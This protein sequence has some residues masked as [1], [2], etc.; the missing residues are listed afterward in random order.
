MN[1]I[2]CPPWVRLIVNKCIGP[3]RLVYP[4]GTTFVSSHGILMGLP[5]TW[6][7]LSLIHVFWV[8]YTVIV[9]RSQ[10]PYSIC[11]DDMTAMM[12]NR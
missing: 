11:G 7:T 6:I 3:Q 1:R 2:D 8:D 10:I 12:T 9:S 4:D 5:L